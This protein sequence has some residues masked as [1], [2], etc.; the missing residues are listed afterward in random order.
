M[1]TTTRQSSFRKL[2]IVT[3]TIALLA[4]IVV[5]GM[6]TG[7]NKISADTP[8]GDVKTLIVQFKGAESVNTLDA[9]LAEKQQEK[10]E[11]ANEGVKSDAEETP[12]YKSLTREFNNIPYAVYTA[13][14][15]GERDLKSLPGVASVYE[16]RTFTTDVS[17]MPIPT[18][19]GSSTGVYTDPSG[20]YT[21]TGYAVAVIDTGVDKNH[22]ALSGRV[23]AEACF[24]VNAVYSNVTFESLC[25][26]GA[27]FSSA[28]GAGQD[29]TI[30]G[31][32]HGTKVA[33]AAAM[34]VTPL[35]ID[36]DG[37]PENLVGA[38]KNAKIVAIKVSSKATGAS[39]CPN[40]GNIC[41]SLQMSSILSAL[42]YVATLSLS[43]P[44]AAVNMS[45][46]LPDIAVAT[47]SECAAESGSMYQPF[48]DAA[49]TLRAHN[50]A[51]VATNGNAGATPAEYNGTHTPAC[52]EG[53]V[54]VGAT[55]VAGTALASYSNN[56][57]L[58]TLLAPG[59]DTG[60]LENYMWLPNNADT[61]FGGVVGTSFAA[62]IV[63]ASF[64]V[65]RE[66]HPNASVASLV[67]LL[68]STGVSVSDNR[69][70]YAANPKPRIDIDA[71][72]TAS[73]LPVITA[74]AGPSGTINE[75]AAI[76][77]TGTA[78]GATSCSLNNGVGAVTMSGS[79]FSASVP[80]KA[81]YILTC[82]NAYGDSDTD[83][84]NF[85]INAAPTIPA[86]TTSE[87]D[88][89]G[90]TYTVN[91]T[92]STDSNSVLEYRLYLNGQLVTTVGPG[93]T[94]Y[95]FRDILPNTAYTVEV[96][97]VDTLGAI[98]DAA[99]VA[100]GAAPAPDAPNTGAM[101]LLYNAN[102]R[103]LV[104]AMAGIVIAG[105]IIYRVTHKQSRS[106]R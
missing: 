41:Q 94:T 60:A 46:S 100:F 42:D 32:G 61:D 55:N 36:A 77:L 16:D 26:G 40:S 3:V 50:I 22:P 71:A 67:S 21:G 30:Y 11:K 10:I 83:T 15:A 70:G 48:R 80:G 89:A 6:R 69:S 19:G 57:P 23:V 68:Q 101:S 7:H 93:I 31:C 95:T 96:R 86:I 13:D 90:N 35:D 81:S 1:S 39:Q 38:A 29:C 106:R 2:L 91:W 47:Q 84:V 97:A 52:I 66:K 8:T 56:G 103:A 51:L 43:T 85:T 44:I 33:G 87:L 72:L 79:S 82:N 49:A 18:I 4:I 5:I 102:T 17:N 27:T 20:S 37:T 88:E 99:S 9:A 45:L 64:A 24:G 53:I 75:G 98:S 63:S 12:G 58:T 59:G 76:T 14:A 105:V 34:A 54:S 25:P 78:T 92:T 65:L 74:F 62:P 73:P 28:S 104:I